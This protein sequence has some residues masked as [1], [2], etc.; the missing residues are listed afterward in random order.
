MIIKD[1]PIRFI[2]WL[3]LAAEKFILSKFSKIIFID[4]PK[5]NQD[6]ATLLLMNHF[7]FNDGPMMHYLCRKVLK[8]EFKVMVLEEQM[9]LFKPLKYIGCFS[10]NKKSRTLVESLDYAASLLSDKRNMLGI[11]PQGGVFSQH[12]EKIHFE[13]GLD[14]IL[15]K[16]KAPIQVVFAVMQLDFL[17]DFKPKAYIY[18]MDYTGE[19]IPEKM[20][21]A[22]NVF[23]TKCR[24]EQK[25][26]Y[27]PPPHVLE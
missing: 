7:S 17:A 19:Q 27:N 21:E 22:Y 20:E 11:F 3:M 10:V 26:K 13:Q 9:L 12:L 25:Q 4:E 5:V 16:N 23:Y 2:Q 15:K 14:R 8:K 18:F 1:K 6:V 24:L